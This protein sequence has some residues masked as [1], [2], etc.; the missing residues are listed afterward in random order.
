MATL[1]DAPDSPLWSEGVESV[2]GGFVDNR[3]LHLLN[4]DQAARLLNISPTVEGRI[5]KRLGVDK[6]GGARLQNPNGLLGFTNELLGQQ[7]L[8]GRW[9]TELFSSTGDA[10]WSPRATQVSFANTLYGMVQGRGRDALSSLFLSSCV[11]VTDS[12]SL[13]Y[14]KLVALDTQFTATSVTEIDVRARALSWFQSRLWAFNGAHYTNASG[15][16]LLFW[17]KPFDG[18]DFTNGQSTQI[19]PDGGDVGVA[20]VPMRDASPR[21]ILAMERSIHM[22]EI[23]WTTD[24]YYPSTANALDFTKSLL[25]PISL[26]TGFAATLGHCWT[27]GI[28]DGTADL[29]FLSREGI[30]SL[31]RSL[32]DS[33]AGAALPLSFDIQQTIDRINW[34]Q[35]HRCVATYWDNFAYFAVPV[36]GAENNNFVIAYDTLRN[37]FYELDFDV[38]AWA[39]AKINNERRFFFMSSTSGTETGLGVASGTTNVYHVY[40]PDGSQVDPFNSPVQLDFQ[41]RAFDF[42]STMGGEPGAGLRIKKKWNYLDVAVQSAATHATLTLSYKVDEDDAW[43]TFRHYF[44]DP[45]DSLPVLPVQLPFGFSTGRVQRSSFVTRDIRPG[46]KIQWRVVDDSSFARTKIISVRQYANPLNPK[47]RTVT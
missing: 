33:Q 27:P 23:Y 10:I 16:D 37:R 24:G 3:E 14:S 2:N 43:T 38:A 11:A 28:R 26:V 41:T 8:F 15:P 20:I 32:T 47:P 35:A 29:L 42:S 31:N 25:R 13:P 45:A 19:F 44:V 17:S 5:Q 1:F 22:L 6:L 46:Y 36:D 12:A 30:R 7:L 18:R 34:V 39:P 4:P 40:E 9:G 21:M